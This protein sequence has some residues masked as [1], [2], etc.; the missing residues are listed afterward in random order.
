MSE[1]KSVESFVDGIVAAVEASVPV[2]KRGR[3]RPR[4]N[5]GHCAFCNAWGHYAKTCRKRS[6]K[7][8]AAAVELGVTPPTVAPDNC[9]DGDSYP[10]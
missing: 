9:A 2:V 8:A 4:G 7:L 1:S 10:Q 6:A 5:K 3:G